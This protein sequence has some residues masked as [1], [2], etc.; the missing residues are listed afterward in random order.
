M[1]AEKKKGLYKWCLEHGDYGKMVIDSF[2][3]TF[4]SNKSDKPEV[5]VPYGKEGLNK[6]KIGSEKYLRFKCARCGEEFERTPKHI[7]N[8]VSDAKNKTFFCTSCAHWRRNINYP[9]LEDWLKNN[10]NDVKLDTHEY[11]AKYIS[12]GATDFYKFICNKGHEFSVVPRDVYNKNKLICPVCNPVQDTTF[13]LQDWTFV[14]WLYP[15]IYANNTKAYNGKFVYQNVESENTAK[16][17]FS[18]VVFN[19]THLNQDNAEERKMFKFKCGK[20]YNK[21]LPYQITRI[22][23]N[24]DNNYANKTLCMCNKHMVDKD[25][26]DIITDKCD[27]KMCCDFVKT[28]SNTLLVIPHRLT[29]EFW[30]KFVIQYSKNDED[31]VDYMNKFI[32]MVV[33]ETKLLNKKTLELFKRNGAINGL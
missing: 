9:T 1:E 12:M 14:F 19:A 18:N 29:K 22:P 13:T 4:Y 20:Y 30:D 16:F 7:T 33:D 17:T 27:G 26:K 5:F 11:P 31:D 23:K 3:G 28:N 21:I 2:I 25:G 24:I 15:I 32:N 10:S 6:V 8:Q